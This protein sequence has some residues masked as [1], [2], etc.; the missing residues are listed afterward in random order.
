M[1]PE[2]ALMAA[3]IVVTATTTVMASRAQAANQADYA[4][5]AGAAQN[6]AIGIQQQQLA[7][8]G[9]LE[10]KKIADRAHQIRARTR[11]A[12]GESGIGTGG[13]T[14][15][16]LRQADF[17]EEINTEIVR[18]N[19]ASNIRAIRAGGQANIAGIRQEQSNPMLEGIMSG[20]YGAQA[21]LQ[22]GGKLK[23]MGLI[24]KSSTTPKTPATTSVK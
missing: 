23:D 15:A 7:D 21:G 13:T 16:L 17:D 12:A 19:T 11:V 2:I 9:A 14:Q 24:G 10:K 4:K 1:G 5:K 20:I 8:Q 6:K 3:A 18:R 22:I